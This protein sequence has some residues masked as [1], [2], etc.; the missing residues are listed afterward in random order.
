[1]ADN[2]RVGSI[3][4]Y[5]KA[6]DADSQSQL[7]YRITN[8]YKGAPL[9]SVLPNGAIVLSFPVGNAMMAYQFTVQA[10]DSDINKQLSSTVNVTIIIID[11]KPRFQKD[12]YLAAVDENAPVGTEVM[13]VE[14]R[15]S[16]E[17]E[18]VELTYGLVSSLNSASGEL[19]VNKYLRIHPQT[20]VISIKG[21]HY[22]AKPCLDL[23]NLRNPSGS[24]KTSIKRKNN[25]ITII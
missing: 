3:V 2:E 22:T 21:K 6:A 24:N 14:A 4:G 8:I 12:S 5:V 11:S 18:G 15:V 7:T 1:M 19:A 20:G 10:T 9:F 16:E 17:M 25:Y 23:R 13:K